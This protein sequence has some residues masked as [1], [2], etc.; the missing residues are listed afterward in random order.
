M[1]RSIFKGEAKAHRNVVSPYFLCLSVGIEWIQ[2]IE[3]ENL[4]GLSDKPDR[5]SGRVRVRVGS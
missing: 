5:R 3:V 1:E 4:L 2:G